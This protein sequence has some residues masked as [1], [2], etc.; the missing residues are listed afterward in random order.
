MN[1]RTNINALLRA[2]RS[3]NVDEIKSLLSNNENQ[4]NVDVTNARFVL[5]IFLFLLFD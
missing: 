5:F 2:A 1:N 4:L 3:N